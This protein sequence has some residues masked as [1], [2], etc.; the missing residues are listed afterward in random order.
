MPLVYGMAMAFVRSQLG[1][2]QGDV[3]RYLNSFRGLTKVSVFI[4][5]FVLGIDPWD[6]EDDPPR[7]PTR[8]GRTGFIEVE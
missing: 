8:R 6:P 1:G 7:G 5:L 3:V 4:L 2:F